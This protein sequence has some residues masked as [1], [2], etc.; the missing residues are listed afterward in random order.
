MLNVNIQKTQKGTERKVKKTKQTP[1]CSK[2]TSHLLAKITVLSS[3]DLS[4]SALVLTLVSLGVL[5]LTHVH[6]LSPFK[7]KNM[8]ASSY[9]LGYTI[10]F[11]NFDT[12]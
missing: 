12:H 6:A 3:Q 5:L 8:C 11:C 9:K 10:C 1:F 2:M 7:H 4:P